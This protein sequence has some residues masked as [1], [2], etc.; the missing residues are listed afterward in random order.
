MDQS[1]TEVSTSKLFNFG[2]S[3]TQLPDSVSRSKVAHL[4]HKT[5]TGT[6][7]TV[8]EVDITQDPV[9]SERASNEGR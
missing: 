5:R 1:V 8:K 7:T 2:H 6:E 3:I 4:L 9:P